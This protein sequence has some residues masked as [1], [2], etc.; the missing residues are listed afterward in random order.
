RSLIK[1]SFEQKRATAAL[2]KQEV[3]WQL[4]ELKNLIGDV[5]ALSA[6]QQIINIFIDALDEAEREEFHDIGEYFVEMDRRMRKE[7]ADV[8]I[9]ISCRHY[10]IAD[11]VLGARISM[12]QRNAADIATY[13]NDTLALESLGSSD[14]D[15]WQKLKVDLVTRASGVFQWARLVVPMAKRKI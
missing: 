3:Q 15:A 10:P 6:Q 12:E 1:A 11:S 14:Y 4:Q 13:I 2:T 7:E 9:C 5:I 8:K